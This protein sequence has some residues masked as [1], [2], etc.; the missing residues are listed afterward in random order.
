MNQSENSE[1]RRLLEQ[2]KNEGIKSILTHIGV[3]GI[4]RTIK[5]TDSDYLEWR[6]LLLLPTTKEGNYDV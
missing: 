1:R 2:A 3:L 6:K 4:L 5:E